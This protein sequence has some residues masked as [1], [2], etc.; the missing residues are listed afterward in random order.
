MHRLRSRVFANVIRAS[1]FGVAVYSCLMS[2]CHLLVNVPSGGGRRW[3][4]LG[5]HGLDLALQDGF[6]AG[7][8]VDLAAEAV[9]QEL[10]VDDALVGF[11]EAICGGEVVHQ[12]AVGLCALELHVGGRV[13]S[14]VSFLRVFVL[15]SVLVFVFPEK[16]GKKVPNAKATAALVHGPPH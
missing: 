8:K 9:L 3:T 15:V 1:F 12:L 11:A 16:P 10:A 13:G 14:Q 4:C 7:D 2:H 6:E 5:D